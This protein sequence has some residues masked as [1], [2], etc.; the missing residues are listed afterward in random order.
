MGVNIVGVSALT[1]WPV[2]LE[3]VT[4]EYKGEKGFV[5]KKKPF[6]SFSEKKKSL[7]F[8]FKLPWLPSWF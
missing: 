7:H 6:S 5:P 8:I 2:A 1:R 4:A 3:H